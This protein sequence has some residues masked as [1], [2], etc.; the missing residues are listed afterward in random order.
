MMPHFFTPVQFAILRH[1]GEAVMPRLN[2]RPGALEAKAAEFLDF[3]IGASAA[4]RKEAYHAG[5]DALTSQAKK[6]FNKGFAELDS[7]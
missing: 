6:Q 2:G 1:V 7:Q 3:L 5:L 4:D